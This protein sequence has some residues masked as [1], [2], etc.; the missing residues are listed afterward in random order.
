MTMLDIAHKD[1]AHSPVGGSSALLTNR[2]TAEMSPAQLHEWLSYDPTT[3]VLRWKK[4]NNWS[5]H[6]GDIVGSINAEGYVKFKI[7][8]VSY[9]ASRAIWALVYGYWPTFLVD[10][11][12]G[13]RA[14]NRLNNLRPASNIQNCRNQKKSRAGLKGATWH[15]ATGKWAA[16]IRTPGKNNHLGLYATEEEAHA[17]YCAAA[18]G[19]YG[20]FARFE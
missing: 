18:V 1:R 19:I 13:N 15:R 2:K 20:E 5:L 8:Q 9:A 6:P 3:G 14:N 4:T 11:R 7:E 17:A 16:Q 10:H 12:D